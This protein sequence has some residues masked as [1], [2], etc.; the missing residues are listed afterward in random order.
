MSRQLTNG[1]GTT[2]NTTEQKAREQHEA[3]EILEKDATLDFLE[4]A[5]RQRDRERENTAL[6]LCQSW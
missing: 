3:E 4:A 5:N 1:R 6:N 2:Q